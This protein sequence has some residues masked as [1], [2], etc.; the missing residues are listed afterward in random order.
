[1]AD[2]GDSS[3]EVVRADHLPQGFST[4]SGQLCR[5]WPDFALA[6]GGKGL[7]VYSADGKASTTYESGPEARH[8]DGVVWAPDG[9]AVAAIERLAGDG[10]PSRIMVTPTSGAQARRIESPG[11]PLRRLAWPKGPSKLHVQT[12]AGLYTVDPA[13]GA[14]ARLAGPCCGADLQVLPGDGVPRHH[15]RRVGGRHRGRLRA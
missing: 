4:Q 1:M 8:V 6:V 7:K 3:A 9:S 2:A 11:G 10:N 15:H 13:S 5:W 12:A 14:G